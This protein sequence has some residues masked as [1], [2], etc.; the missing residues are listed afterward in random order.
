L[1][2]VDEDDEYFAVIVGIERVRRIEHRHAM[3]QR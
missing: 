1:A 3:D 2:Q